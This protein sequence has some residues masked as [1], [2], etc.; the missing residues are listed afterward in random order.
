MVLAGAGAYLSGGQGFG[1]FQRPDPDRGH[2]D[3]RGRAK[4]S[5]LAQLLSWA[6][7][8]AP[9]KGCPRVSPDVRRDHERGMTAT[10]LAGTGRKPPILAEVGQFLRPGISSPFPP[11]ASR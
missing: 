4:E 5:A 9:G 10:R 7:Q 8:R 3:L 1:G 6:F 2:R 11:S